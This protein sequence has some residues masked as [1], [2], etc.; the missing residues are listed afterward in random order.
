MQIFHI[1]HF[2]T[3]NNFFYTPREE[4]IHISQ[5]W[6]TRGSGELVTLFLSS[7]QETPV[8]KGRNT[9]EKVGWDTIQLENCSHRYMMQPSVLHAV[10]F[11]SLSHNITDL[12]RRCLV[13]VHLVKLESKKGA[14]FELCQ[15]QNAFHFLPNGKHLFN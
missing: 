2:F 14:G 12:N 15:T 11:R 6:R 10:C 13:R 5:I 9:T 4:W 1:L 3:I 8:Q 7:S